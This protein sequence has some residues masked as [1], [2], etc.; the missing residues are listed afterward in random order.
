MKNREVKENPLVLLL[1]VTQLD[2][3]PFPI[4]IFT[5]CAVAQ[6]I[7]DITGESPVD[8]DMYG[9]GV[10]LKSHVWCLHRSMY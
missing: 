7:I 8:I 2:G 3:R 9:M 5:A 1:K 10:Q 4:G 6:W